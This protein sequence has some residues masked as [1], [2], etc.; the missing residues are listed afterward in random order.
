MKAI[1]TFAVKLP[2]F[3][4]SR[5]LLNSLK[6]TYVKRGWGWWVAGTCKTNRIEQGERGSKIRNFEQTYFL[7]ASIPTND[8]QKCQC[9]YVDNLMF[10]CTQKINFTSLL[11]YWDIANR[12]QYC[13]FGYLCMVCPIPNNN[14]THQRR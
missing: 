10:V 9:Q 4:N 2:C 3:S 11:L 14:Q 13:Y 12:W 8:H 6:Q 7:N 1:C 5:V